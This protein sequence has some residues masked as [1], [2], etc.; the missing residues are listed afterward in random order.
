M[1]KKVI[2]SLPDPTMVKE[3]PQEKQVN[4]QRDPNAPVKSEWDKI[5]KSQE[6]IPKPIE[7]KPDYDNNASGLQKKQ[8]LNPDNQTPDTNPN[9]E[10]K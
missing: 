3:M 5:I 7:K 6:Q 10:K 4:Q 9:K 8:N 1:N 2:T